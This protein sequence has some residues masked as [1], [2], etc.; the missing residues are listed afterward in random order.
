M[1]A[2]GSGTLSV[3]ATHSDGN[4][5]HIDITDVWYLHECT[6][7]LISVKALQAKGCWAIIKDDWVRYYNKH[8]K[9]MFVAFQSELGY[10]IQWQL[11]VPVKHSHQVAHTTVH[12][13]A[14]CTVG[15]PISE[16]CE[17]V[18]LITS[19][20]E[21]AP[22]WHARLGHIAFP[23][24]AKMVNEGHVTGIDVPSSHFTDAA[25]HTC[26]ICVQAKTAI[27]PF[28]ASQ[29][30]STKCLELV[31]SDLCEYPVQTLG[32]GKYALTVLDDYSKYCE[33]RILKGKDRSGQVSA[34]GNTQPV[35][36]PDW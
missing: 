27:A 6:H 19:K 13:E 11:N 16:H 24:L 18:Q 33:V 20:E 32:K 25:K 35:G 14:Q 9:L 26:G 34:A 29:R 5:M 17:H 1:T 23:T 4:M 3:T 10:E 7:T 12:S 30:V 2:Y 31:H 28:N 22:L 21:S 8:G 36:N 15:L